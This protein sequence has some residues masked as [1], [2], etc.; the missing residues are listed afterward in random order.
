MRQSL[1]ER[2]E[3]ETTM[4]FDDGNT[5]KNC[6][7]LDGDVLKF[8]SPQLGWA[9]FPQIKKPRLGLF[10]LN[11]INALIL[12]RFGSFFKTFQASIVHLSDCIQC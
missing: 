12:L 3:I 8:V 5:D 11:L 1:A 10:Y 6:Q 7:Y 9:G 2:V 4:L